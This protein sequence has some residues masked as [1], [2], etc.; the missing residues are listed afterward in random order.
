ME[1]RDGFI[2][3]V[4]NY[5]DRWCERCAFTSHCRV[6]ASAAEMDASFDPNMAAIVEASRSERRELQMPAWTEAMPADDASPTIPREH[7]PIDARATAYAIRLHEWLNARDGADLWNTDT[8]CAVIARFALLVAMKINR[9]RTVSP[10]DDA[11]DDLWTSDQDGSAKVALIAMEQS[12]AAWRDLVDRGVTSHDDAQPFIADLVWLHQAL[13]Q[14]RP[15]ARRF[16]RPAF[17][18]PDEVA[19]LLPPL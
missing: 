7:R 19:R 8:Q 1:V 16:V 10:D 14:A 2:V 6:F 18:E 11:G 17:D 13:E 9:A 5:C 15:N 12:H 4:H 3:S